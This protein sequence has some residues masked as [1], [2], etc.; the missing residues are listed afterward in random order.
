M[1]QLR[2]N[3]II[4]ELIKLSQFR[5]ITQK[6]ATLIFQQFQIMSNYSIYFTKVK[7]KSHKIYYSRHI[8][9]HCVKI[10][11]SDNLY[12]TFLL[13]VSILLKF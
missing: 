5:I 6:I 1:H 12:Y 4:L 9:T 10:V 13:K 8:S 2:R 11:F 7:L 3:L